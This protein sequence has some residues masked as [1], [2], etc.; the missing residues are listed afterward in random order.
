MPMSEYDLVAIGSGPGGEKS[1]I[2]AGLTGS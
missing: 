2:Q 1:A